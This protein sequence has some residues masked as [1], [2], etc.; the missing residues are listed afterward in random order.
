MFWEVILII[1]F[2]VNFLTSQFN[3]LL[4][5]YDIIQKNKDDL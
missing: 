4:N 3:F 2:V 1:R 5:K